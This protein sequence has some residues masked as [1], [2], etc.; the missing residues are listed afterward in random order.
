MIRRVLRQ[1]WFRRRQR[2]GPAEP[3][4]DP[5]EFSQLRAL[6]VMQGYT[7]IVGEETDGKTRRLKKP[8][9]E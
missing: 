1:L 5:A 7:V 6:L 8:G 2:L 3:R 4:I 9:D